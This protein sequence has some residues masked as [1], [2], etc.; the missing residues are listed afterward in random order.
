MK[1]PTDILYPRGQALIR[2]VESKLEK[3]VIDDI[4]SFEESPEFKKYLENQT[5]LSD[6]I[7]A[8]S[9]FTCWKCSKEQKTKDMTLYCFISYSKGP[10]EDRYEDYNLVCEH[11]GSFSYLKDTIYPFK[12]IQNIHE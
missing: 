4:R 5:K 10:D 1:A 12:E 2:K 11:C 6:I 8:K 9:E 3:G 7:D